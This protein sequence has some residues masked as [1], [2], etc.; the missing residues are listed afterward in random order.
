MSARRVALAAALLVGACSSKEIYDASLGWRKNECYKI[1]DL[2]RRERCLKE[3]DRP[4]D[5]YRAATDTSR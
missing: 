2:D 1:G 4:Y 5:A 3:A